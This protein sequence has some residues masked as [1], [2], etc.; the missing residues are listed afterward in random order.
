M[1]FSTQIGHS[2]PSNVPSSSK[3]GGWSGEL[4]QEFMAQRHMKILTCMRGRLGEA[5]SKC[6]CQEILLLK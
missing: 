5:V 3:A 6:C 2:I 1:S 4:G